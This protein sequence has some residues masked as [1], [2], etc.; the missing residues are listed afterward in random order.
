M[1]QNPSTRQIVY[2]NM[3]GGVFSGLGAV[4]VVPGWNVKAVADLTGDGFADIVIQNPSST[5]D[6]VYADMHGGVFNGWGVA[7]TP[8]PPDYVVADAADVLNNGHADLIVQQQ[9]TGTTIYAQEGASGFAGWGL[10]SN[11]L[12]SH[13]HV[14]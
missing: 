8:L 6:A 4:A 1:I 13:F 2:A 9:S 5:A 11:G 10:V 3:A 14:V 7:T 12:N